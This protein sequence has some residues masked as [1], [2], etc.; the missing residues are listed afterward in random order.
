[1]FTNLVILGSPVSLIDD[2][3]LLQD[4][5]SEGHLELCERCEVSLICKYIMYEPC[6]TTSD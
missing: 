6:L 2:G 5:R 3:P 4:V 1:M